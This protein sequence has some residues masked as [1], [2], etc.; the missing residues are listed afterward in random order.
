[1]PSSS[2]L[3]KA[4]QAWCT[5]RTKKIE[6]DTRLADAFADI[7]D[8]ET[9]QPRLGCATTG[10]LL[11]ELR[12]RI[13]VDG[14]LDYRTIGPLFAPDIDGPAVARK[15]NLASPSRRRSLERT[16]ANRRRSRRLPEKRRSA[17]LNN[18]FPTHGLDAPDRIQ[19]NAPAW[20]AS[21]EADRITA[22]LALPVARFLY[23]G[24]AMKRQHENPKI[25]HYHLWN[26]RDAFGGRGR[27]D[28]RRIVNK[29]IRQGAKRQL[30]DLIE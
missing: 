16:T 25:S 12:A 26:V 23:F 19:H 28:H 10:Q 9:N 17:I 22:R 6:M 27:S 3:Q 8:D 11:N 30:R 21:P 15:S 5:A 4:A 1:M 29:R 7:L 24:G 20:Y 14:K 18:L 2:S 13:E